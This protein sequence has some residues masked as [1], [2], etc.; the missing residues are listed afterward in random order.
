MWTLNLHCLLEM[1]LKDSAEEKK[2]SNCHD[3][4]FRVK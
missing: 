4:F 2:D 3:W 1:P